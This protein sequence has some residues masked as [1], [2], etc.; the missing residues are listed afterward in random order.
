MPWA[1]SSSEYSFEC[2][3]CK[4]KFLSLDTLWLHFR[5][6]HV[7]GNDSKQNISKSIR[8]PRSR[9]S[10]AHSEIRRRPPP[11]VMAQPLVM[12]QPHVAARRPASRASSLGSHSSH[13]R[14]SAQGGDPFSP[15]VV[16]SIY[17][18]N[19]ELPR[20]AATR[21]P[22]TPSLDT[23]WGAQSR[24]PSP[25][26]SQIQVRRPILSTPPTAP[27]RLSLPGFS[28]ATPPR[29]DLW[30]KYQGGT[31]SLSPMPTRL[32]SIESFNILPRPPKYE[33][34]MAFKSPAHTGIPWTR[35]SDQESIKSSFHPADKLN[36]ILKIFEDTNK[37]H[38]SPLIAIYISKVVTSSIARQLYDT[39]LISPPQEALPSDF[40]ISGVLEARN[41]CID[42]GHD[43]T[44]LD[45]A[46]AHI[47]PHHR[48]FLYNQVQRQYHNNNLALGEVTSKATL[49]SDWTN[50]RDR[51]NGWLLHHR[52][53]RNFAHVYARRCR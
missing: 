2:G 23:T 6:D 21:T 8:M 7:A 47:Y 39:V 15:D 38:N 45:E 30:P 32:P 44:S 18:M 25:G 41:T 31:S 29:E 26:I 34:E 48:D 16:N 24:P 28:P 42:A 5:N 20:K 40:D 13:G 49:L 36:Q 3:K 9:T 11:L 52:H 33:G 17:D 1:K 51:I 50:T 22:P 27:R 37:S 19:R 14:V 10:L 43:L 4:L 35:L 53:G 46:L 12:D